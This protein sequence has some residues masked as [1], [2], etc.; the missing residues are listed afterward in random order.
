MYNCHSLMPKTNKT[1]AH[2]FIPI[3]KKHIN[4]YL[5]SLIKTMIIAFMRSLTFFSKNLHSL[6]QKNGSAKKE[7]WP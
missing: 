2:S 6:M 5:P 3:V 1:F 4:K 7:L